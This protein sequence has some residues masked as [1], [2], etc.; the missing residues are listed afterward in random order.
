MHGALLLGT[1]ALVTA[2]ARQGS[3]DQLRELV[4]DALGYESFALLVLT[5]VW[6]PW[7]VLRRGARLGLPV[8]L[9]RR[10]D[11]GIWVGITGIAHSAVG[12][13][14]HFGG[15]FTRYFWPGYGPWLPWLPFGAINWLGLIATLVLLGLTLLSSDAALRS[16]GAPRWKRWQRTSY[17]AAALGLVHTVGYQ[18][19]LHRSG[20]L[21]ALVGILTGVCVLAQVAAFLRVRAQRAVTGVETRGT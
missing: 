12:L 15:D 19:I 4:T 17:F 7:Q 6:G 18:L 5:L 11:L 1:V 3:A 16:L 13:T 9:P 14:V 21:L 10:R 20:W 2:I 8:N